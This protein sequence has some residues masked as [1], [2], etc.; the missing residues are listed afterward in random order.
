MALVDQIRASILTGENG[1]G[2]VLS[3]TELAAVHGVSRI[4]IRDALQTLAAEK[5]VVILPGK[6]ARVI[7]LSPDELDEIFDLRTILECDL[8][9]RAIGRADAKAHAEAE[10]MLQ[11]S[12]LEAGRPGWHAG[13]WDFHRTLYL[14]AGRP[15]QLSIIEE[16]RTS[17]V[18]HAAGYESLASETQR[19][20]D[21]H[22]LLVRAYING[23]ADE[24][25]ELLRGHIIAARSALTGAAV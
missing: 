5:I 2:T 1:P 15:R 9:R 25:C 6:G 8:L 21:D 23:A 12:S 18:L 24:A 10:Y 17:C 4:P 16:L 19:W 20:L 7:A 22:R 14:P 11:K 3:Q 13:D